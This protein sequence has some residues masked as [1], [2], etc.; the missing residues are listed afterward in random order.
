MLKVHLLKYEQL[1]K[2]QLLKGKL[3]DELLTDSFLTI[4]DPN[5]DTLPE[6]PQKIKKKILACLASFI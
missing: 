3:Q 5:R 6:D 1:L 2:N 4:P